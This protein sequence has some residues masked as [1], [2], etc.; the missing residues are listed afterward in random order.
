MELAS[1]GIARNNGL[2]PNQT[3]F[4]FPFSF[5]AKKLLEGKNLTKLAPK[6]PKYFGE[7]PV[8][9]KEFQV[10]STE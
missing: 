3:S 10:L 9:S 1:E 6:K 8:L 5:T 4:P 2:K 7:V